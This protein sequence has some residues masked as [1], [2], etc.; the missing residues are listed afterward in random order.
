MSKNRKLGRGL[1][2][3]L[4]SSGAR[5]RPTPM[6]IFELPVSELVQGQA[7]PR[8]AI[9][10]D[11]LADLVSSIRQQG[12]LQP[13]LVRPL[14]GSEAGA[15]FV[16]HEIVAGERRWRA[17]KL[18]GLDTVPVVIRDLDDQSALAIALIEN[19][20]RE[21]LNPIEIAQSLL[22]LTEEFGLTHQQAA[23]S[24]GRSRSAV[25]N[26]LRLLDLGFPTRDS[27]SAGRMT[28]GH[29]RALLALDAESQALMT[30]RIE[31][32]GLSVRQVEAM[33]TASLQP[34]GEPGATKRASAMDPQTRWLQK[35]LT[36]EAGLEVRFK[37]RADG[38]HSIN[39]GFDNLEQLQAALRKIYSLIGWVRDTAGPRERDKDS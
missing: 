9:D 10:D 32:E 1:D 31:S 2:A 38:G 23:D 39:I 24:I 26:L 19:L 27:L 16:S 29:A 36:K 3:L 30:K 20:Q 28:M 14:T 33:V 35:Q 34:D 17:A 4:G 5:K 7:Q 12:V 15:G 11:S 8:Q 6:A 22:R 25:S 21:D 37:N 18:A 13:V